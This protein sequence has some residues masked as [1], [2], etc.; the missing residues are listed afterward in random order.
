MLR[1]VIAKPT[2]TNSAPS[3]SSNVDN[4]SSI[5]QDWSLDRIVH[6]TKPPT[7]E[8]VWADSYYE[9]RDVS[10]ILDN[11][12]RTYGPYYPLKKDIFNAFWLTP[13][14]NVK[15]VILGQDPYHQTISINGVTLPRATG[16]SFSVRREDSIPSSLKN[17]YTELA[18]TVR[19]FVRPDHG[20]LTEWTQQ[21][22]L[23]LNTCLTVRP[24]Q[25]GSHKD[26][27]LG[28][29]NKVFKAIAVANPYCIFMLW[30]RD[31]QKVKPMLGERS[32]IL[33]AAH[34]SG[35]SANRGFFGC[36]HFNEA[37]K[38]LLRIGK[39]AIN[40]KIST[41]AEL[42]NPT[43]SL[44]VAAAPTTERKLVP[45]NINDLPIYT[46]PIKSAT[47][48][49]DILNMTSAEVKRRILP[50]IPNARDNDGIKSSYNSNE[51]QFTNTTVPQIPTI[52]YGA[53]TSAPTFIRPTLPGSYPATK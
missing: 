26:I 6:E 42:A 22:V 39:T 10:E 8:K 13:L 12:E 1:L 31:A 28:F 53:T 52:N 35:L 7:W 49:E 23:L 18:N 25:A 3:S 44:P 40:W 30:G 15:V 14:S 5:T 38:H 50:I 43:Q 48:T 47:V 36:N 21:G 51:V 33:E 34:P 41:L 37:N 9:F 45:I 19:G 16:L 46:P 27:W 17:I 4:R 32:I 11:Q 24:G 20:D 29:I 2:I